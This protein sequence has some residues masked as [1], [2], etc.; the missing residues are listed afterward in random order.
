[1]PLT[2]HSNFDSDLE[3]IRR[4]AAQGPQTRREVLQQIGFVLVVKQKQHFN[5]LARTGSSNGV[6]WR[7]QSPQTLLKRQRLQ[8]RGRLATSTSP[9]QQGIES[10]NTAGSFFFKVKSDSVR[11]MAGQR[12][13][14]GLMLAG[15]RPVF[16]TTIPANW[17]DSAERVAQNRLDRLYR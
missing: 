12:T 6:T 16:P 15:G 13:A 17:L 11:L 14:A 8:R 2:F 4:L 10:G 9:E 5:Q 7:R 1:M 3:Q